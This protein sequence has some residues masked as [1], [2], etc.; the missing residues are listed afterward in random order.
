MQF[1]DEADTFWYRDVRYVVEIST[2]VLG[3]MLCPH[4][5]NFW[6]PMN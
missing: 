2:E 5:S 4:D 6:K 3:I 1:H